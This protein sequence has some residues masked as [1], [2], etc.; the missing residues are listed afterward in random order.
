MTSAV[1]W[2][3]KHHHDH[4]FNMGKA[5]SYVCTSQLYDLLSNKLDMFYILQFL[6]QI[7]FPLFGQLDLP[8][9]KAEGQAA[10]DTNTW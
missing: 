4:S 6:F 7:L 1:E 8:V 10:V 2:Y 5:F 9:A 3:V